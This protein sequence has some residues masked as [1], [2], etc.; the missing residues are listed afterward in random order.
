MPRP[1]TIS[2]HGL[3]AVLVLGCVTAMVASAPRATAAS[4]TATGYANRLLT[5]VNEVRAW[6]G[7]P[8]LIETDGTNTVASDWTQQLAAAHRLSHNP[9]LTHDLATHGSGT[10]RSCGE[11]VGDGV[12]GD[13]DGLFAAYIHSPEHRANILDPSYQYVGVAVVFTGSR[14][15]NT[16]DFVD[17]YGVGRAGAHRTG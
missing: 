7:L 10:W 3:V 2:I 14:A 12:V 5:L 4:V 8:L 6:Y 13:P 17:T 9:D 15:W 1:A 16:F 11:N